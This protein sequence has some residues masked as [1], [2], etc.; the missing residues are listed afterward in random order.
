MKHADVVI[1][2]GSLAGAACV[3]ELTRYGVDAVALERDRFPRE[4]VCGGFL[5]PGAVDLLDELGVLENVRAAGAVP[6]RHS[7]VRMGVRMTGREAVVD[8]P[9][10][11][12]GISRKTLDAVMA[13][14]PGIQH[15]T[16]RSVRHDGEKFRVHLDSGEISARVVID[17]AGKLSRF[18]R[19]RSV[20]QFG[21][22]FYEERSRGDV[23]DFWFFKE[24]YG[25]AVSVEGG[26]SNACILISKD[27]ITGLASDYGDLKPPPDCLVTGPVAYRRL[28]S[29]F[30]AI[31][32]AAGMVDPF[33]G[34][35]MRH[36]LD[37]GRR[38]A[39]IVADGLARGRGYDDMRVRYESDIAQQWN[40]K[41]RL[42]RV[43]RA[44]SGYPHLMTAG[45]R[46]HPE[47]W[48][49]KLWA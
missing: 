32:D 8:L 40:R 39:A 20:A 15:G 1:I 7:R 24:G 12:L 41:R 31:G 36:A 17:A 47:Y 5:S 28:P 30:I 9:R 21:V 26:R 44:M 2:G 19:R 34:E 49:R 6:V 23:L 25:G 33:C 38:A 46:L 45:F 3:R 16:V 22:Q 11:G 48:F 18:T 42:G 29:D 43:V 35:G 14:H 13:D 10:P 4:K 37:T 27:A